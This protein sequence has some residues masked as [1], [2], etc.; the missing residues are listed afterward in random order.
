MDENV[1]DLLDK[2]E[3]KVLSLQRE[4]MELLEE[5]GNFYQEQLTKEEQ[6]TIVFDILA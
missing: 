4:N 2:T 6:I 1:F 3:A 5:L